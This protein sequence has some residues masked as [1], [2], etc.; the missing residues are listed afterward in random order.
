MGRPWMSIARVCGREG[1]GERKC[2]TLSPSSSPPSE[3][4]FTSKEV[5]WG[6]YKSTLLEGD[7]QKE[8][9]PRR[10]LDNTRSLW[11]PSHQLF[12]RPECK[13]AGELHEEVV[14]V[15]AGEGRKGRGRSGGV[16]RCVGVNV[17][18]TN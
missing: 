6:D 4:S 13:H 8:S 1:E 2:H 18:G 3:A 11:L 7:Q 17:R 9:S 5:K 16:S 14:R 12:I 15:W 10:A